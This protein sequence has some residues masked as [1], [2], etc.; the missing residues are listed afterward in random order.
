LDETFFD[1]QYIHFSKAGMILN[2]FGQAVK[3]D[4]AGKV[5]YM[6]DTDICRHPLEKAG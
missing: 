6:V 1:R 2:R 5:V 4:A 3:R